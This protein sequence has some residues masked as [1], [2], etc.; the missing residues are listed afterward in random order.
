MRFLCVSDQ[1]D[2]LVY[3]SSVKERYSDV[4]AVFCAGDLP[5][6]YVDFIVD[7]LGKP[8]FFV[9]GNHDLKEYKYYKKKTMD[10]VMQSEYSMMSHAHGADYASNRNIRSKHLK[11]KTDGEKTTPLL[12]SGV[13]GSRN[14]NNGQAQFTEWQM[15]KQLLNLVPGLLWNKL[16]YG[17]YCDVFLT[18]ASPRHIHDKEDPCHKGFKCFNWFI[19]K[20][21]P[22]LMIHGHI[23]LYDL[24]DKRLSELEG[25]H[26]VNAYGHI[27]I[28]CN[29]SSGKG[30]KNGVNYV[31]SIHPSR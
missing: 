15:K 9:F 21:K 7:S 13:T 22:A 16:R 23:H 27:V 31:I 3:S 20:F 10:S 5:M 26:I 29:L 2:P 6:D 19:K 12:I 1:I 17:R 28:D 8:T 30:E 11:F 14:Y 24:Q 18:H 25:T 4:D